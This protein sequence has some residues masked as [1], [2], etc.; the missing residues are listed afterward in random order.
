MFLIDWDVNPIKLRADAQ[1]ACAVES[2]S[3]FLNAFYISQ[4][5][6]HTASRINIFFQL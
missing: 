4:F 3:S 6:A 1:T 5:N 2:S